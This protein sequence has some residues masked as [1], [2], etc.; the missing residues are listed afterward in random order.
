MAISRIPDDV[1]LTVAE[2]TQ[3]SATEGN[4]ALVRGSVSGGLLNMDVASGKVLDAAGGN[5]NLVG[6]D[7][8]DDCYLD[9]K[10]NNGTLELSGQN[11]ALVGGNLR[12]YTNFSRAL[13]DK[14]QLTAKN[15][16]L[17][18]VGGNLEDNGFVN[19]TVR[20]RALNAKTVALVG[21]DVRNSTDVNFKV[22]GSQLGATD[23]NATLVGGA[24][25]ASHL[26]VVFEGKNTLD[27]T[28][29]N[30]TL[31]DGD[32][33][34]GGHLDLMFKNGSLELSGKNVALVGG[35][36]RN[37]SDVN[38]ALDDKIQLT[39]KNGSFFLVG[40]NL[41]DNRG[42]VILAVEDKVLNAKTVALVGGDVRN[43]TDVN[44]KVEGSQL[45]AT[46]G[47]ATLVGG[48]VSGSHLDVVFEGKNTL[49]S[50]HGNAT[51][52]DGD[53]EDG[54]HL[55]LKSQKGSMELCG[56]NAALVSGNIRNASG[57][58]LAV[59]R[60]IQLTATN[61]SLFLVG[62][63]LEDN[64]GP[65]NLTVTDRVLNAKT[66]ALVG[67]DVCNSTDVNM[68]VANSQLGVM[69][70]NAFLVG[71]DVSGSHLNVALEGNSTLDSTHG[72]AA[73]LQGRVK[74]ES[75]LDLTVKNGTLS[76]KNVALVGAGIDKAK[77]VSLTVNDGQ[78]NATDGNAVLVGGDVS[79]SLK[80]ES[81]LDLAVKD[82]TLS[83]KS[84]ALVGG[85]VRNFR[86]AGF[87]ISDSQLQAKNGSAALVKGAVSDSDLHMKVGSDTSLSGKNVALVGGG[88][89]KANNAS[90][91]VN[92]GELSAT[93]GN[94][95]LVSGSVSESN[96]HMETENGTVLSGR[97]LALVG[98]DLRNN[99]GHLILSA[100]DGTL[101]T[102]MEGE[103][104]VS[105]VGGHLMDNPGHL[106]LSAQDGT[107]MT[108]M[109]GNVALVGGDVTRSGDV[110]LQATEKSDLLAMDGNT[111]L[112]GGTVSDSHVGMEL[113][114]AGLS[115]QNGNATLVQQLGSNN[116][117]T[118]WMKNSTITASK[119]GTD[120]EPGQPLVAGPAARLSGSNNTLELFDSSDNG[121]QASMETGQQ[122]APLAVA[123]L[124]WGFMDK[125]LNDSRI[126]QQ[127]CF[128]NRVEAKLTGLPLDRSES[129]GGKGYGRAHASMAGGFVPGEGLHQLWQDE[130]HD[131]L[132]EAHVS[133]QIQGAA[134]ASLGFV[135]QVGLGSD[136]SNGTL[137][138]RQKN[139]NRNTLVAVADPAEKGVAMAGLALAVNEHCDRGEMRLD[140]PDLSPVDQ[141]C[142]SASSWPRVS[143]NQEDMGNNSLSVSGEDR[144]SS[145]AMP[146]SYTGEDKC[147]SLFAAAGY[148][149]N[150]L[151]IS[152]KGVI[153]CSRPS[154]CGGAAGSPPYAVTMT[155]CDVEQCGE[156][157]PCGGSAECDSRWPGCHFG[158][159]SSFMAECAASNVSRLVRGNAA[160]DASCYGV[161]SLVPAGD[162]WLLVTRYD[163]GS[164]AS[165][166]C[167]LFRV[168]A[169]AAP[170]T[171]A[172]EPRLYEGNA[173]RWCRTLE[174][175]AV[176][177]KIS[178]SN[179][180]FRVRE[181]RPEKE[182]PCPRQP[183]SWPQNIP[184]GEQVYVGG[185]WI[186]EGVDAKRELLHS[187]GS[188]IHA[189]QYRPDNA[190]EKNRLF[191]T[192]FP[193][194][195]A[196]EH[197]KFT[198]SADW[199]LSPETRLMLLSEE[200]DGAV[201]VWIQKN[202]VVGRWS[203]EDLKQKSSRTD[204]A[205]QRFHLTTASG[206]QPSA[207]ARYGD[208][209]YSLYKAGDKA[210]LQRW[211]MKTGEQ[212]PGWQPSVDG[213]VGPATRL[214]A[215]NHVLYLVPENSVPR[216]DGSVALEPRI[217]AETGLLQWIDHPL[218]FVI[219]SS[220]PACD[221]ATHDDITGAVAGSLA[222]LIP[223]ACIA[224]AVGC[225]LSKCYH[226]RKDKRAEQR[227]RARM[228]E[229]MGAESP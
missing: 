55:D 213:S 176:G 222:A 182:C 39:V 62:G 37:S 65:V 203:L 115:A 162:W 177:K 108:A 179:A 66:V 16:S 81:R 87:A 186:P 157:S 80:D 72:N 31:L 224:G 173:Y 159:C 132:I 216:A 170:G 165:G 121:V 168:V 4:A 84:V 70:G 60:N 120:S 210:W 33:E 175:D 85:D 183:H 229:A 12:N 27:S 226:T 28:H 164:Q 101:M 200:E 116:A 13:D 34:D 38:L 24:V 118:L 225:G 17:F 202:G 7:L 89:E 130:L 145:G 184:E 58:S 48:A 59:D 151:S 155:D 3:L 57:V 198:R 136:S 148:P 153:R 114:N 139:C 143:V 21:G 47:N 8:A 172:E 156:R 180:T 22:E 45:G 42:P 212:D 221:F 129:V 194:M 187:D 215:S 218:D 158:E 163:S 43:S 90:L 10:I 178:D 209:L 207:L 79:G 19:L 138:I 117:V 109:K 20:D 54:S 188:L 44:F 133:E 1:N 174:V 26:D 223:A 171:A 14:I 104:S 5:A 36:V 63:N 131:N 51:L 208:W 107:M 167:E 144:L 6:G 160:V 92:D 196:G 161:H 190:T 152:G 88:I 137:N 124:G 91:T 30:A 18:L 192:T 32:L 93:D 113:D 150:P 46:D 86:N 106:H 217:A 97:N 199:T 25:S 64:Q 67:G 99:T 166:A 197:G 227:R 68:E 134:V 103:G 191:W 111:T 140:N 61:G 105:L 69:D 127:N 98:G 220:V 94:V 126:V 75:R 110:I 147:F 128:R 49:D 52:L 112:V 195:S 73:L 74:D 181:Y 169:L 204:N 100:K 77:N 142:P 96:L 125:G 189:Y 102:S 211:N 2:G 15:G 149:G 71:G 95:T 154:Q 76:G 185:S 214:I 9:L 123:S 50:T 201:N 219:L 23:G 82:G 56:E 146:P 122:T 35:D 193:L 119:S 29:G 141:G 228:A 83:G 40:G 41:E 11:V 206:A 205:I 135:H 78:L 53:L